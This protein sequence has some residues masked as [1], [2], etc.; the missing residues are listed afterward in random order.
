[1]SASLDLRDPLAPA[2]V[3]LVDD[4]HGW[5]AIA[6]QL[7]T[8]AGLAVVGEAGSVA[9]ATVAATDLKPD[10]ALVDIGLPDGNGIDLARHLAALPWRPRIVLTSTNPDAA[11]PDDVRRSGAE[12]FV[13][14]S[15]LPDAPLVRLLGRK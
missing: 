11:T 12:R 10:A 15:D 7:L 9:A 14:K 3:L 6:R 2:S 4:D 1:M 5:R 8:A 13:P